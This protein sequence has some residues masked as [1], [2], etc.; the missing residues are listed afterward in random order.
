MQTG[1]WLLFVITSSGL[2]PSTLSVSVYLSCLLLYLVASLNTSPSVCYPSIS[3]H[4]P[5]P[6]A[7][8]F[9]LQKSSKKRLSD[10]HKGLFTNATTTKKQQSAFLLQTSTSENV[11]WQSKKIFILLGSWNCSKVLHIASET[12]KNTQVIWA[13]PICGMKGVGHK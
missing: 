7:K 6:R 2:V 11:F 9:C 10:L 5:L 12:L 1:L 3:N 4:S 8:I 13:F